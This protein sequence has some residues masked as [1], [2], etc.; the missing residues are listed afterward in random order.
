MSSVKASSV[1]FRSAVQPTLNV[2]LEITACKR[3]I[4]SIFR[5]DM[6]ANTRN[7]R[8]SIQMAAKST[9][10]MLC[11]LFKQIRWFVQPWSRIDEKT[12]FL[13]QHF[14]C[15]VY[16]R[17]VVCTIGSHVHTLVCVDC[18]TRYTRNGVVCERVFL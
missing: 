6:S 12:C 1:V 14:V 13:F 16:V 3:E 15:F 18:D 17:S 9:R 11:K 2:R 8:L 5:A 10:R 4:L 7:Q